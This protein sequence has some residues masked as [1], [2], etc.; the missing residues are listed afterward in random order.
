MIEVLTVYG[1]GEE[2]R[3][4]ASDWWT[5]LERA[6]I[7]VKQTPGLQSITLRDLS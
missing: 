2:D 3:A 1:D 7:T 6:K 4:K 5:A